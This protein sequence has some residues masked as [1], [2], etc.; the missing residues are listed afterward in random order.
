MDSPARR[1]SRTLDILVP[2]SNNSQSSDDIF[3]AGFIVKLLRRD[4]VPGLP[5]YLADFKRLIGFKRYSSSSI[6]IG[7]SNRTLPRLM[8]DL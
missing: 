7:T 1:Q 6:L 2:K 8:A 4:S 5:R 3:P